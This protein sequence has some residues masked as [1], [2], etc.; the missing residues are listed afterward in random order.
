MRNK[1]PIVK[2]LRKQ[3]AMIICKKKKKKFCYSESTY[4]N[5]VLEIHKVD[6][7]KDEIWT[8]QTGRHGPE[9]NGVYSGP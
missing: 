9:I 6:M 2:V 1:L 8:V 3:S 5:H 4:P 7:H